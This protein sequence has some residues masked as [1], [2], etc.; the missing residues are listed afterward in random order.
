MYSGI[1]DEMN[2]DDGARDFGCCDGGPARPNRLPPVFT[3]SCADHCS[4]SGLLDDEMNHADGGRDFGCCDG[5]PARLNV[6]PPILPPLRAGAEGDAQELFSS[7]LDG[8]VLRWQPSLLAPARGG[9][10]DDG[11]DGEAGGGVGAGDFDF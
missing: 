10:D 4:Q 1:V 7:G 3:A 8:A 11:A 6:S 2:H 5:G 9:G